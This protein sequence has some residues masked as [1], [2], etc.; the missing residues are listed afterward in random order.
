MVV[1]VVVVVVVPLTRVTDERCVGGIEHDDAP[2]LLG[3]G[4][5]ALQLGPIIMTTTMVKRMMTS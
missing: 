2:L 1:V 3:I 4:H 5:Q